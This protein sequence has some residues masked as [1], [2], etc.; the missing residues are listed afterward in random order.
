MTMMS[1]YTFM[2]SWNY[3]QFVEGQV[4]LTG[5]AFLKLGNYIKLVTPEEKFYTFRN[6][7]VAALDAFRGQCLARIQFV[8]Q[9]GQ[10][11]TWPKKKQLM[12]I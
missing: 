7:P 10:P 2:A 6:S 11:L 3:C 1:E 4:Q 12:S 9:N 8:Q 5:Q